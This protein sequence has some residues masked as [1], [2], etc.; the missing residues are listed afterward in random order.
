MENTPKTCF[1]YQSAWSSGHARQH[2]RTEDKSSRHGHSHHE[3]GNKKSSDDEQSL[4]TTSS[5]SCE[6]CSSSTRTK[7][8]S[9]S[10]SC[11]EEEKREMVDLTGPSSASA[12]DTAPLDEVSV[13]IS[14]K[15][16]PSKMCIEIARAVERGMRRE[17][18][19]LAERWR[20]MRRP[21]GTGR[22]RENSKAPNKRHK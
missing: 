13:E 9:D 21:D 20:K 12:S 2:D 15:G 11:S 1:F 22:S 14:S 6:S 4:K 5:V 7:D 8:M 16:S 3:A 18:G 19:L 17:L 10:H